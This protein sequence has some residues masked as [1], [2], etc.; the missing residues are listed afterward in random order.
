[1]RGSRRFRDRVHAVN[2]RLEHP[3]VYRVELFAD[4]P[5]ICENG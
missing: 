2:N 5:E 3:G 4:E 1:M